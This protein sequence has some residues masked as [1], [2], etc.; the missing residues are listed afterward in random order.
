MR[1]VIRQGGMCSTE[2]PR[3]R[4]GSHGSSIKSRPA[5]G[6]P[7]ARGQLIGDVCLDI[8][9]VNGLDHGPQSP[10]TLDGAVVFQ[11]PGGQPQEGVV[12][13]NVLRTRKRPG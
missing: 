2:P 1:S 10:G 4:T 5:F 13:I 7:T 11:P 3:L 9:S 8:I 6:F 12:R